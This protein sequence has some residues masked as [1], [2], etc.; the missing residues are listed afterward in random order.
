MVEPT[1]AC[2]PRRRPA[3]FAEVDGG[4]RSACGQLGGQASLRVIS[5]LLLDR[6]ADPSRQTTTTAPS[7]SAH[8]RRRPGRPSGIQPRTQTS[9]TDPPHPTQ[10]G[11]MPRIQ[12]LPH[13]RRQQEP[14]I[15]ST[16]EKVEPHNQDPGSARRRSLRARR[17]RRDP[18]S[19]RGSGSRFGRC[20]IHKNTGPAPC[21]QFHLK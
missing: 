11:Q 9:R 2:L 17:T 15:N 7:P 10:K 5:P 4:G 14:L 8:M 13:I 1:R 21:H 19:R 3:A 16:V 20:P 6:P 12:P 18:R